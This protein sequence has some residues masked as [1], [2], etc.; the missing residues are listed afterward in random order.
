MKD[1]L[2][3]MHFEWPEPK[4][5]DLSVPS[6]PG[7]NAKAVSALGFVE[8][9]GRFQKVSIDQSQGVTSDTDLCTELAL[10]AVLARE[11]LI[12]L[13]ICNIPVSPQDWDSNQPVSVDTA[14]FQEFS[15]ST[16]TSVVCI[17]LALSLTLLPASAPKTD[18]GSLDHLSPVF[19]FRAARWPN[20]SLCFLHYSF[21]SLCQG[22]WPKLK[23]LRLP[24]LLHQTP[25]YRRE[26]E[27]DTHV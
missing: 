14:S 10:G 23:Q 5:T 20:P 11:K 4:N 27:V 9:S 6:I 3:W 25:R 8:A 17:S 22:R 7:S 2:F 24:R 16:R 21:L 19:F 26:P 13:W 1:S 18:L 12:S 15:F